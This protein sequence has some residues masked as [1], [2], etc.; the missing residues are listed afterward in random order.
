MKKFEK[1]IDE[2]FRLESDDFADWKKKNR[3]AIFAE[4]KPAVSVAGKASA[5]SAQNGGGQTT[6]RKESRSANQDTGG[7][8]CF[9]NERR[10]C[11]GSR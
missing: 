5:D 6:V 7:G 4:I 2:R 11:C 3:D 10:F 1:T 9:Q 8:Y